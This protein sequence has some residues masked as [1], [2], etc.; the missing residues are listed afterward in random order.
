MLCIFFFGGGG[1]GG[2]EDFK[3][4]MVVHSTGHLQ[5]WRLKSTQDVVVYD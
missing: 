5:I 3:E 1:G 2:G 4:C